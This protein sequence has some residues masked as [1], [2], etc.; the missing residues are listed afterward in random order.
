M[1]N[2]LESHPL[3]NLRAA[4]KQSNIKGY[5]TMKKSQLINEMMKPE[6]KDAFKDIKMYVKPDRKKPVKKEAPKKPK[7][8][9]VK[10]VVKKAGNKNIDK[11]KK[12]MDDYDEKEDRKIILNNERFLNDFDLN[13][14]GVSKDIADLYNDALDLLDAIKR[15]EKEEKKEKPKKEE[16]KKSKVPSKLL[17]NLGKRVQKDS[18]VSEVSVKV[19]RAGTRTFRKEFF[20]LKPEDQKY[21][22][23]EVIAGGSS[24]KYDKFRDEDKY[25]VSDFDMIKKGIQEAK[26]QDEEMKKKIEK[27]QKEAKKRPK[28]KEPKKEP[29]KNVPFT[30]RSTT[31]KDFISDNTQKEAEKKLKKFEK[32]G[33]KG[34]RQALK[35]GG[36]RVNLFDFL[37]T[38]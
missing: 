5:S 22:Q 8:K 32:I 26:K 10:K 35:Q 20:K 18:M 4:V 3:K 38:L 9:V 24:N 19:E 1:R 36:G 11:L 14:E 29:P 31:A 23:M 2:I 6:H 34:L 12:I 37:N 7:K 28:K 13:E 33:T 17:S 21:F 30:I 27:L 15:K 16:P 25:R